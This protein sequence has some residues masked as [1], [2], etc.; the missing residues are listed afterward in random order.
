MDQPDL[1]LRLNVV[2]DY[3]CEILYHLGKDNVVVDALSHKMI[4]APIRDL[5]LRM[6]VVTLLLEQI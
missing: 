2:K 6:I 4:G 5:C 3:D 1:N